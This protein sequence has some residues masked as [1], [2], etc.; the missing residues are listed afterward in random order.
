MSKEVFTDYF[1][2][3]GGMKVCFFLFIVQTLWQVFAIGSDLWLSHWTGR[4]KDPYS[5]EET[6]YYIKVYSMLGAGAAVMVF[7]RAITVPIV[8][9]RASRHLFNRMTMALLKAP[10]R[11]FDSNPIGR[12]VNRYGSDMSA[13]DFT[14]RGRVMASWP[15][16]S[17]HCAS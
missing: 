7:I 1:H 5:P 10:L 8:G 16:S 3:L 4:K 12:I 9:L 15:C 13:V 6:E 17:W 2:S 11:F 14:F